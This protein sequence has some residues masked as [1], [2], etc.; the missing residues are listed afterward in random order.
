MAEKATILIPDV[1]GF[2]DFT[3]ARVPGFLMRTSRA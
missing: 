3:N 1:S 2:T